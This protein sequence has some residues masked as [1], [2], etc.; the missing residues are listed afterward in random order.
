MQVPDLNLDVLD[1]IMAFPNRKALLSMML[2]TRDPHHGGI[3]HLLRD[4]RRLSDPET[5]KSFLYFC[6]AGGQAAETAYRMAYLRGL[7]LDLVSGY[8]DKVAVRRT[9]CLTTQ[10]LARFFALTVRVHAHNF[11][12]LVIFHCRDVLDNDGGGLSSAISSLTSLTHLRLHSATERA[13]WLLQSLKSRLVE[14]GVGMHLDLYQPP[15]QDLTAY[16]RHSERSMTVMSL[17]YTSS[18]TGVA[19]YPLVHTLHA[20][21]LHMP[22]T[23]H[24]V[25]TF[26]NLQVLHASECLGRH[27]VRGDEEWMECRDLNISQQALDGSW[28]SLRGYVGSILFLYLLG[29]PCHVTYVHVCDYD[30]EAMDFRQVRAV[31]ADT[32]PENLRIHVDEVSFVLEQ[33]ADIVALCGSA[34]FR[35]LKTFQ[36]DLFLYSGDGSTDMEAMLVSTQSQFIFLVLAD[37]Y[38]L[39]IV[40]HAY[41][42]GLTDDSGV[43]LHCDILNS[44]RWIRTE[45][46]MVVPPRHHRGASRV[47]SGSRP[48]LPRWLGR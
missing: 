44:S 43:H 31:V 34:D 17:Y 1:H 33:A 14:V 4:V 28:P 29:L 19:C 23:R 32:Q 48:G 37:R 18:P 25:T 24:Y 12:R 20:C 11:T 2:A 22:T 30:Y 21:R 46:S 38:Q 47:V 15:P 10:A 36:L 35:A 41:F 3:K 9:L 27:S 45:H 39:P 5:I 26:P 6:D 40:L 42:T 16:V 7:E 13:F 8:R